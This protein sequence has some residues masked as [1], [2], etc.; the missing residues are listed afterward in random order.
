MMNNSLTP[1]QVIFM[2]YKLPESRELKFAQLAVI[3]KKVIMENKS[4]ELKLKFA[5]L[6]KFSMN[7]SKLSNELDSI[8]ENLKPKAKAMVMY[9]FGVSYDE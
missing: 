4:R 3:P 9:E 5:Q 2:D 1:Q 8:S 6:K 7:C